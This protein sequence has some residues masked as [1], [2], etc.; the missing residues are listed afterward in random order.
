MFFGFKVNQY[1]MY[2]IYTIILKKKSN[3]FIFNNGNFKFY[4]G[5]MEKLLKLK[6]NYFLTK[7]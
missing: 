6:K 5:F 2:L 1:T 7:I 4:Y 3:T